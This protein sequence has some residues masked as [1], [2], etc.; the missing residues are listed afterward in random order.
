MRQRKDRMSSLKSI[1]AF[2]VKLMF[3]LTAYLNPSAL[4]ET[5]FA[6]KENS[7]LSPREFSCITIFLYLQFSFQKDDVKDHST[8]MLLESGARLNAIPFQAPELQFLYFSFKFS[9]SLSSREIFSW[10]WPLVK[11]GFR[12]VSIL[13]SSVS[14]TKECFYKWAAP[15]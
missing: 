5:T 7:G 8:R 13:R 1:L 14:R 2:R 3:I 11:M 10:I 12:C 15:H 6:G 9:C 4:K